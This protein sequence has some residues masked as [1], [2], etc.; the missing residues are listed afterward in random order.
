M[1]RRIRLTFL[2]TFR[3]NS[4][5]L[6]F[7]TSI[8]VWGIGAGCFAATLNNFLVDIYDLSEVQRGLLEVFR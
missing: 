6:P 4:G 8:I 2:S 7:F 1:I 3:P 5:A